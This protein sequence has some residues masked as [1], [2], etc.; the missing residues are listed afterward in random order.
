MPVES[1]GSKFNRLEPRSYAREIRS[2]MRLDMTT[3]AAYT[4]DASIFRRVP[5]AV[6]EPRMLQDIRDGIAVAKDRGWAVVGRGGGTSVAGNAIGDGLI[7]DT[8]R[9]FNRII[10][11]DPVART[12]TVQPGVVCDKLREAVAEYGL[13]YGPDPSTHSRCTIGGMVANNACGS[14]SVA[15][16]TAADNVVSLTMLLADGR[17]VTFDEHGCSDP[18][19]QASIDALASENAEL[20]NKE[21]GRF[22]RQVSGFGLHYL[23][24]HSAKPIHYAR[25]L[26]GSEG[27]LGII[28]E[29]TVNLVEVPKAKALAVLAF[30]TV[31]D[32]AAA[33]PK[34]RQDGVATIEGMG[35]DLLAALR[36]KVG[37]EKAGGNLPG[38]RKG[39][40]SGGW[41]YCEVVGADEDAALARAQE[42]AT[43]VPTVDYIVVSDPLDMREL[44]RIREASAGLVTRL[45]DGG[46]AWPNWED[47]AV[48]PENLADYLR[49]L[50]A[51]MDRY[52]LR[53][54]PFGHFGEGCVHVRISF[55]F[56]TP[57]GVKAFKAFMEDAASL[58]SSYGGSL[59][60]EHGDGRARSALLKRMY[61]DEMRAVFEQFKLLFDPE[62]LFNPGV[63]VWADEVT[64][65]LRMAPGQRTFELTPVHAFSHDRGSMVNAVN[66]CVGVSACRSDDGG[67]CP[68]FQITG[69]EVHSTRGRARIFS[70]MFRGESVADGFKSTEVEEALDLCLSCKACASECPVNVDMATYK[71]EFLNE[72]YRG[73]LRPMAH[74]VMG[75][76]PLIGYLIHKLPVV[77]RLVDSAMQAPVLSTVI[78][79]LGGLDT[80][81][82]LIN[83][84][85]KS[86]RKWAAMRG[87]SAPGSAG[88]VVL[89]PDSFN[90][91]LDTSPA[92]AAVAVLEKL[93]FT[94]EIPQEFVCCGLTWHSTGQLRMTQRVLQQT[95]RVMKP[96]LDRGLT[97]IGV[98]PSC[99]VMLRSEATELCDDPT[100]KSL[101]KATVSF[102]EFVTPLIEQGVVDGTI[103]P[104]DVSALTQIHCHEKSLG[105]PSQSTRLLAAL[106]VSEEQIATGCCGL[107][108]N[109]GFEKGH[110]EMSLAL[111]ER[112]LFP[113]VREASKDGKE[114][115]ADGFSCRT[116]ISQGTGAEAKHITEIVRDIIC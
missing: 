76:L 5:Q 35:G 94:V 93:G 17:L 84:A 113:R 103:V 56:G 16:G 72:F 108:G 116:Q 88:T 27:T 49:D 42:V 21:L 57:E 65:G 39:I 55:D 68:S 86:L 71:S 59:S 70:E 91:S 52:G 89:W 92:I 87:A 77:P 106:G 37:Q 18:E 75:W 110:A 90:T 43:C 80:N 102:A 6:V 45:P 22:P 33:A 101:A 111:G 34:L 53:G 97:V 15:W 7:I 83:F 30:E 73:K 40:A 10:A 58:V 46:E 47:S 99:T 20:I 100:L 19:L 50:Y 3:R 62:R 14:H 60:G 95:A 44:W 36:S 85:H 2:G 4:S 23:T 1:Q 96:Y 48:P 61:S 29:L 107:A 12:A 51:L 66:R 31:F 54:I 67:M 64:D 28:T 74:Y 13:T 25:A 112:E 24:D 78:G 104:G 69:D 38:K 26:A 63:L 9:Y 8:S 114:I 109:W 105:D 98:E 41:L 115:I 32:A 79:K 81:R 11:V 82:S